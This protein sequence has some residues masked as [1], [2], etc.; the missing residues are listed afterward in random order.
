[1]ATET[2]PYFLF[3]LKKT[4]AQPAVLNVGALE[5]TPGLY[6]CHA[7]SKNTSRK[8]VDE[9][10]CGRCSSTSLRLLQALN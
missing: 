1:M 2:F 8:T 3:F 9:L 10:N 6:F 7:V 4:I 5:L